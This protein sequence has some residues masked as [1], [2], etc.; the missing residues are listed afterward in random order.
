LERWGSART[1]GSF[2]RTAV[3]VAAFV[4]W[5][6][7]AE[8]PMLDLSLFRNPRFTAASV[9]VAKG[10]PYESDRSWSSPANCS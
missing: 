9:S 6:R 1:I 3:L 2:A 4:A 5:E 7:R 10:S 8:Q